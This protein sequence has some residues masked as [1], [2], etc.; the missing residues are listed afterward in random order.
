MF[1]TSKLM[2]TILFADTK[3]HTRDPKPT[4][5]DPS[6]PKAKQTHIPKAESFEE[7]MKRRAAGGT[8]AGISA[9]SAAPPAQTYGSS[10]PRASSTSS[11]SRKTS[12]YN[13][14]F[15]M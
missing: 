4:V 11:T 7:Y 1:I 8:K 9:P 6:D 2:L 3:P 5:L 10:A 12:T 14:R 15:L 13:L